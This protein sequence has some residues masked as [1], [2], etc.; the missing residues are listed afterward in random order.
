M[1]VI[2]TG[3]LELRL[4]SFGTGAEAEEGM[5]FLGGNQEGILFRWKRWWAIEDCDVPSL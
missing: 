1:V 3:M 2:D 4:Q 5:T